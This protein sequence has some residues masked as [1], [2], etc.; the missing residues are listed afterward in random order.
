MSSAGMTNSGKRP[1]GVKRRA[2][3][4]AGCLLYV[5]V[6][7]VVVTRVLAG[8][9]A[10]RAPDSQAP[11]LAISI[12]RPVVTEVL[13]ITVVDP[14]CAEACDGSFTV[15]CTTTQRNLVSADSIL[16]PA[17]DFEALYHNLGCEAGW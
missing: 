8:S 10:F 2:L 3:V 4:A 9:P 6:G 17:A 5:T 12:A 11:Q 15:M 1:H 14:S 13:A 7:S 16:V